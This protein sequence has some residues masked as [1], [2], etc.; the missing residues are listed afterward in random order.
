MLRFILRG[1]GLVFLAAAL[2]AV[3][4]DAARS[5]AVSYLLLTP[6]GSALGAVAPNGYAFLQQAVGTHVGPWLWDGLI[7]PLLALPASLTAT[8]VGF[9]LILAG[10]ARHRPTTEA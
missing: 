6:I 9:L 10:A 3:V 8:V 5:L 7:G 4:V 1:L 2:A